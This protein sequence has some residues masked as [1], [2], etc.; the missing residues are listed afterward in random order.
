MDKN[1]AEI[2]KSNTEG[3]WV[4]LFLPISNDMLTTEELWL[5]QVKK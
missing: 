5:L 2:L 4:K 1:K 3:V